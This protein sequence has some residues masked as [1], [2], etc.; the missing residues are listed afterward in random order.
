MIFLQK[1]VLSPGK[2]LFF[3]T[4]FCHDTLILRFFCYICDAE[5]KTVGGHIF[6]KSVFALSFKENVEVFNAIGQRTALISCICIGVVF[7]MPPHAIQVWGN[8]SFIIA[9]SFHNLL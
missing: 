3:S 7:F 2:L 4:F 1:E 8:V 6:D 9:G 5:G